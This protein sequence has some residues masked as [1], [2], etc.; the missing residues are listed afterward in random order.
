MQVKWLV[1]SN[2][3]I[4]LV[5]YWFELQQKDMLFNATTI[6]FVWICQH[7]SWAI[8]CKLS[9]SFYQ[10]SFKISHYIQPYEMSSALLIWIATKNML[11]N[12]TTI[13]SVWI[14]QHSS[15]AICCKLSDSLYRISSGLRF[16]KGYH[17]SCKRGSLMRISWGKLSNRFFLFQFVYLLKCWGLHYCCT[18]HNTQL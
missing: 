13:N 10:I 2:L 18:V 15:G 4:Y 8:R 16:S 12:T 6:N 7:S 14:C 9:D 17:H 11:F 3:M 5:P 1:I